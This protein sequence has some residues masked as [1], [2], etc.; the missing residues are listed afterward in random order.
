[1]FKTWETS[2]MKLFLILKTDHSISTNFTLCVPHHLIIGHLIQFSHCFTYIRLAFP[3]EVNPE[4]QANLG[5]MLRRKVIFYLL[6]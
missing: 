5:K 6:F 2:Y 3:N 1:M 4:D